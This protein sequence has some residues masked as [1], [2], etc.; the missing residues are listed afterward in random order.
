MTT[1]FQFGGLAALLSHEI[2]ILVTPD[3][4]DRQ[5]L[6]YRPV[7]DYELV[8]AVAEAHPLAQ[9]QWIEPEDLAAETLITYP[10]SRERLDIYTRFL[11]PAHACH[12]ATARLKPP[13]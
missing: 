12:A 1:A 8:L 9:K 13:I 4:I 2:D 6:E 10:V 3:P 5:G 7:F 11:V